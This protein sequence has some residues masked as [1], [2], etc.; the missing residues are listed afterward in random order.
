MSLKIDNWMHEEG[1]V[2]LPLRGAMEPS[3]AELPGG[4]LVMSLRTQLGAVFMAHSSDGGDTWSLPQT[5]G[6]RAPDS[7]NGSIAGTPATPRPSIVGARI[8][9]QGYLLHNA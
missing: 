3:V 5:S 9:F 1:N 6:L 2:W 4:E 8:R 7:R